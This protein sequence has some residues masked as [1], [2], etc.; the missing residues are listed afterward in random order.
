MGTTLAAT[1][2][3]ALVMI[4]VLIHYEVLYGA[5]RLIPRLAIP[6][7]ACMPVVIAACVT[8]HVLEI[9]LFAAAYGLMDAQL[10]MGVLSG[11]TEGSPLDLFYFS[12][13]TYTTLGYGDISPVGALRVTAAIESLTGLVLIGWSASSARRPHRSV[14]ASRAAKPTTSVP[15]TRWTQRRTAGVASTRS[16]TA[17]LTQA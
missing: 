1:L 10:G 15:I 5:S 14:V 11:E 17:A 7:R 4:S 9:S 2:T 16:R 6:V 12:A 3:L 8:A 13:T